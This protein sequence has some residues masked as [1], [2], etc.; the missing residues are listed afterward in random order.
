MLVLEAT[1]GLPQRSATTNATVI[2]SISGI[3]QASIRNGSIAENRTSMS[4]AWRQLSAD[5]RIFELL[6][7][8]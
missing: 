3:V 8:R 4:T 2:L 6:A 5:E 7:P 1:L